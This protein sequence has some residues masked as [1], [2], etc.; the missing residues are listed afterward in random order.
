MWNYKY[1]LN[2]IVNIEQH[3][4]TYV[5]VCLL[6][7]YLSTAGY[8]YKIEIDLRKKRGLNRWIQF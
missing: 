2:T 5:Y 1:I 8:L 3:T 6:K 4:Y 7:V